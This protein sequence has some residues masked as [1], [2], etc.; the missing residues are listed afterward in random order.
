MIRDVHA[1]DRHS[2]LYPESL[3]SIL[4]P[5]AILYAKGNL[6]L[7]TSR[8][9]VAIVGTRDATNNGLEITRRITHHCVRQGAVIVSGL[10]L[11]IDAKAH[12]SCLEAAGETIAVL[13]HGLHTAQ[14]RQNMGLANQILDSNG[15]WVSEHPEGVSPQRHF[16]VARNRIQVGL[17]KCSVVVECSVRSGTSTHA[18]FCFESGHK[19]FSVVPTA[20]NPFKLKSDGP[21][22]FVEK[23]G[24]IPI[25]SKNDYEILS[26]ELKNG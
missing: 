14:P 5:P 19:L 17:S 21:V 4:N 13:A 16:F 2:D 11:G 7:L 18:K 6:E 23:Y 1:I 3:H 9:N 24:A 15:L 26:D 20:G 22:S 25:A 8:S 12:E 10:A